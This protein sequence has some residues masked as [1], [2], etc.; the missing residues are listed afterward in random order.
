MPPVE[1]N[2]VHGQLAKIGPSPQ[3]ELAE[4]KHIK[5]ITTVI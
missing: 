1:N 3:P 4:A 5:T 2:L